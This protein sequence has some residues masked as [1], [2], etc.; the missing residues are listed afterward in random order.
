MTEAEM[1]NQLEPIEQQLVGDNFPLLVENLNACY[2][3]SLMA[4][5]MPLKLVFFTIHN[6]LTKRDYTYSIDDICDLA[7]AICVGVWIYTYESWND[8]VIDESGTFAV[9]PAEKYTFNALTKSD[10]GEFYLLVFLASMIL[11]M[12]GR[13]ILMLQLTKTFGPMLRI[14]IVMIGDVLKFLFIWTVMLFCLASVASLLFGSLKEYSKF[15]DVFFLMFGTGLGNYD[16]TVFEN[17]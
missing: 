17:L 2:N 4:L 11:F 10:A 9:T 8:Y 3:L 1:R 14:I 7:I 13:F 15:F 12:W 16:T 5:I 6:H